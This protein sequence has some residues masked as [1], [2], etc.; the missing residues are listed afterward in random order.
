MIFYQRTLP[1]NQTQPDP[2]A[3]EN[4]D[5]VMG[6]SSVGTTTGHGFSEHGE[7]ASCKIIA[8]DSNLTDCV[9]CLERQMSILSEDLGPDRRALLRRALEVVESAGKDGII[10]PTLQVTFS[11]RFLGGSEII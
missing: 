11:F 7:A 3:E 4:S 9:A 2:E 1:S 10:V 6:E 5:E 8:E